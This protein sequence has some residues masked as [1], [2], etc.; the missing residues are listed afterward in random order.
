MSLVRRS[1]SAFVAFFG[2]AF[3]LHAAS[4]DPE[5]E[6]HTLRTE[7]FN[8]TFHQGEEEL[9]EELASTA[10]RVH[11][12][13]TE[14]MRH[15]PNRST[16][17]VLVDHTDVANG[18]AQTLPVN[19]I[20]IFVT[21]PTESSSLGLYEDWLEAIFTHEYAHILHLDTVEGIPKWL[22]KVMGRIISVNQISPWWIVEGLATY[23]E[24]RFTTGGRGRAPAAQMI[25]RMSILEDMFP[26]LGQMDGWISDPPGGNLRYLFG[27]SFLQY[28]A[29]H[30]SE[31]AWTRWTHSYGSWIPYLLPAKQ[32]FGKSFQAFYK[33]WKAHLET[34]YGALEDELE[35]QGL[36]AHTL[37]SDGEDSCYGPVFSPDGEKLVFSCSDRAEGSDIWVLNEGKDA[38]EVLLEGHF[39]KTLSWRSDSQA[40]AFSKPHMVG[41]Y[42]LYEDVY[43]HQLGSESAKALTGGKRARDP[44]F[45]PDGSDL[46]MVKNQAQNNNLI[47]MRIDQSVESLTDFT[48]HT[49]LST[50]RFSPNGQ[51]MVLSQWQSGY[52]DIWIYDRFGRPYRRLT[53]DHHI[54]RDPVFSAD[55]RL[56]YFSSDRTGIANLYAIDLV[57]ETLWQVTNVLGGAFQPSPSP[58]NTQLAFQSYSTNGYDIAVMPL[59]REN[60]IPAG[61]PHHPIFDAGDL[62]AVHSADTSLAAPEPDSPTEE[63]Q[64][65][66]SAEPDSESETEPPALTE[67]GGHPVEPYSA[68]ETLFPPRFVMPGIYQGTFGFMGVLS[69]G[70]VDTL[71]NYGYSSFLTYRTDAKY[72]GGG[73]S[74]TINRWKPIVSV[75]A[76]TYAVPYGDIYV[77][78]PSSLG[79][80]IPGIESAGVRYWDQ[81]FRGGVSLGYPIRSNLSAYARYSGTYRGPLHGIPENAYR[82][83]LPTRGFLSQLGGSLRWARG[84]ANTYSISPEGARLLSLSGKITSSLLGSYILNTEDSPEAFDQVQVTAELREYIDIPWFANHVLAFRAAGGVSFGD[85]LKYGSFRLGGNYGE[86][87]YYVLPDEIISLRGWPVAATSGDW[88]Y[89]SS[90]EYRFPIWRIDRGTGTIP[91]FIRSMH[92]ALFA[93][94]GSAFD[95]PNA[96]ELPLVGTGTELRMTSIVGWGLPIQARIGYAFALFPSGGIAPT[97]PASWYFR[98]G[99]S[100]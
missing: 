87:S 18:Y 55:G 35:A 39:A 57:E 25:I 86:S 1:L 49:Q 2:V 65:P 81:R 29:D 44:V 42:N 17:V 95:D 75:S 4:Y 71:R 46:I 32:V 38:P 62:A 82:P 20:V 53:A 91:L 94:I 6:W 41:F 11:V 84:G 85:R 59:E 26:E 31:D 77:E 23:Q 12:L 15:T 3:S 37:I 56:I 52:R 22:R 80:N 96:P 40:F 83:F 33:D 21:A 7:H 97:S 51:F 70:G 9:A 63:E 10:E 79:S 67:L 8:I 24:T 19:T 68:A 92:G 14:D 45:S 43:I 76:T 58:D 13:L 60:W 73:G 66:E 34:E 50:P 78:S 93:D 69:T 5:L 47:R 100:F 64:E 99:S 48:D 27:Q 30:S 88:Y 36:T 61:S 28:I 72:L 90:A 16:E 74:F 54:D 98:L 89:L